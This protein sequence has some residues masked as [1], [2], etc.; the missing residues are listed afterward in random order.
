MYSYAVRHWS[1]P[2][3]TDICNFAGYTPLTLATILGRREIFEAMLELTKVEFWRF[4]DMACSAYPLTT[5]DTIMPDGSTSKSG[6]L[7]L[8][9][10]LWSIFGR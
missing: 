1:K 8:S 10:P 2:A 4:S 9:E 5:L 7:D 3:D 6:G